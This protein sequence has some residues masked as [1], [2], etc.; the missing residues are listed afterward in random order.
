M[1][2]LKQWPCERWGLNPVLGI[3]CNWMQGSFI[4]QILIYAPFHQEVDRVV[5]TPSFRMSNGEKPGMV[6]V[7]WHQIVT[8]LLLNEDLPYLLPL[9][10]LSH[11]P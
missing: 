5:V 1:R 2:V 11:H 10:H 6:L 9:K 3:I 4:P 8:G 7:H